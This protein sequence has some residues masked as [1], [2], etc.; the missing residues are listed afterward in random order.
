MSWL[1]GNLH[2]HTD[3]SD[4]D[5]AP[6]V[7]ARWYDEAGYDFLCIS[8]HNVR[9]DPVVLQDE[10]HGEG[11][12]IHL[13]PGE[14][15]TTWWQ[16]EERTYALHVNGY[17]TSS[18][19]GEVGGESVT[20]VLQSL[21]DRIADDGGMASVNHPNF[22]SSVGWKDLAALRRLRFFEV[23]NGHPLSFNEGTEDLPSMDAVWDLL[24]MQG[25]Q[26]LGIAVDDAHYF[27]QWGPEFS[28]PGR[29]WVMVE[30]KEST[31]AALMDSL[32][33]GRFY[34]SNGPELAAVEVQPGESLRIIANRPSTI[35]FIA[36]GEVVDR[37][38]GEEGVCDLGPAAYVR[39]R[40][41]DPSGTAWVQPLVAR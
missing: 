1:K 14:E 19:L 15:L 40:V 10:L 11:R 25:Q 3:L 33:A 27:Q 37:I 8:D 24:L 12:S 36:D 34:S 41:V 22:W 28:N 20:G 4:G 39:V 31:S 29:G 35:E 6:G 18:T 38:E 7:V 32:A 9:F 26:V 21:I 30:A 13:L 23:Y 2:T 5:S 16:D 17:G